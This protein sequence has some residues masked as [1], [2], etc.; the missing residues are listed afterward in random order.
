MR[1]N[2]DTLLRI[3]EETVAQRTRRG[4]NILAAYLSGSLL[5]DDFL[6][7][8]TTDIDLAFIHLDEPKTG[9]EIV[10]LTDDV[11]LDIAH[12]EQRDFSQT[13]R[14][15]LHPWMGPVLYECKVLYDPQHFLDFIQASV[16]GQFYRQDYILKRAQGQLE[17]ARQIWLDFNGNVPENPGPKHLSDYLRAIDHAANAIAGLSGPP[18]TE[19]RLLLHFPQRAEAAGHPGLYPAL[20]GMLGGPNASHESLQSWLPVWEQSMSALPGKDLPARLHPNR[21]AYYLRA[22]EAIL[23]SEHPVAMLWPLLRTWTQAAAL[24]PEATAGR[25]V[26]EAACAQLGLLGDSFS[27]RVVALDAFLDLVE[28]TIEAWA[29]P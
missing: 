20:L 7:G 4:R 6:L 17:H 15:R 14:L 10:R 26:W 19:R 28:E 24:M 12:Y 18:L 22:F 29:R 25:A 2:R 21:H 8:G 23:A 9:R 27:E 16:R 13:R 11:H 3:A 5:G 1:I